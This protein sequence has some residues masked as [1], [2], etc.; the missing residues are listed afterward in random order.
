MAN[1]RKRNTNTET[2]NASDALQTDTVTTTV[3]PVNVNALQ[4]VADG[5]GL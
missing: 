3:P 1:T 4:P 5:Y 2:N